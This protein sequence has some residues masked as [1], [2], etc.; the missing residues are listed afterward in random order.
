MLIL[1]RG[2][3]PSGIVVC[4]QLVALKTSTLF[5]LLCLFQ[6]FLSWPQ[7]PSPAYALGLKLSL[8]LPL[9][10]KANLRQFLWGQQGGGEIGVA[11]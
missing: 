6:N 9:A 7:F 2:R 5:F 11:S 10:D 3:G 1:E 8:L 4:W